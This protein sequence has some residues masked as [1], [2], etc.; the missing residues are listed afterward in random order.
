MAKQA[1]GYAVRKAIAG[2]SAI[3]GVK[4]FRL[5]YGS[6]SF[7][8]QL[9]RLTDLRIRK[10]NLE[11][12]A[13]A[14]RRELGQGPHPSELGISPNARSPDARRQYEAEMRR[15]GRTLPGTARER[16][17]ARAEAEELEFQALDLKPE[18]RRIERSKA[19]VKGEVR[20]MDEG[21]L[22]AE[23][24]RARKGL[25]AA[26]GFHSMVSGPGM[27]KGKA[28]RDAIREWRLRLA[29]VQKEKRRRKKQAVKELLAK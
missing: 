4:A 9:Q 2:R 10:G 6:L 17:Q 23:E 22:A 25:G 28:S 26:H 16:Q 18:I 20:R 8:R 5:E 7:E 27:G 3:T 29:L 13:A 21:R 11:S 14:L 1:A 12:D 19:Y 24:A 15:Q